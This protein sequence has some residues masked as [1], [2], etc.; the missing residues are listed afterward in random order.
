[1]EPKSQPVRIGVVGCGVV[2]TGYY[3]PYLMKDTR[4]QITAVCDLE[5]RRTQAC[6]RLFG[7]REQYNDYFEMLDK[8]KLDAVWILTA[9]GT[10]VKFALAA[11]ERG[12][13][14]LLQKPMALTLADAT[15]IC[16]AVRAKGVKCLVEPSNQSILHPRWAHVR[17][18]VQAGV[19]GRPYWF[20]AIE[21]AGHSYSNMLGSNPY[22]KSAFFT[23]DSGGILMDYPYTPSK[24]VTVLGDCKA[25]TGNATIS[26]PERMIVSEQGYDD[27]MEQATDPMN[28]NYWEKVL[29]M[30]RTEPVR[31]EAPDNVFST[32]EMDSGWLG[33][34]HIGRPFHPT[35]KGTTGADFMVFGEDGNL[36]TGGGHF[37]SILSRRRD[38]LPEISEDGWYHVPGV[39][40]PDPR[41]G[42]WPKPSSF[43]YY[44][45]SS[46][47][48]ISCILEDK[49]P[50]PNVDFGRHI[51]EMM[52]GALE[53]ARTGRRYEMT[54][55]TRGLRAVAGGQ[56]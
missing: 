28:C 44:S 3:L 47:H 43:D 33:V 23:A 39:R 10:H 38:L 20:S 4:A 40:N 54:T 53:S 25:V 14:V 41:S 5:P 22:G 17:E 37:A 55:T 34:F 19:L 30:E 50:I 2:A 29:K 45:E 35:L 52:F 13:H 48:L 49:E 21:T 32:Y 9:P 12:L 46:K 56:S 16:N 36:T 42:P 15:R 8:A 1:M 31:M 27:Y 7:A 51:T 11:V 26:V 24:I 18:L 6:V